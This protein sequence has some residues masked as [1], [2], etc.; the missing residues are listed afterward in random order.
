MD[1]SDGLAGDLAKLCRVSGVAAEVAVADVPL[2]PAVRHVIAA[3]PAAIETVLT[4]GDDFEIIATVA[5]DR[6]EA[7][8]RDAAA[9]GVAITRI[10][11]VEP[12]QGVN[13]A[14]PAAACSRFGGRPTAISE[15][16]AMA[17]AT[18]HPLLFKG[19]DFAP[20]QVRAVMSGEGT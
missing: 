5:P 7:F 10:G 14:P 4:G 11:T 8:R 18:D 20:I 2:S 17:G 1:V 16:T 9:A 19:S 3:E 13:S 12:G 6:F 15:G